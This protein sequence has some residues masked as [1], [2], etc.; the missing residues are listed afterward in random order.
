MIREYLDIKYRNSSSIVETLSAFA[1]FP[2]EFIA[3]PEKWTVSVI[4]AEIPIRAVPI[5]II[6][7]AIEIVVENAS[8]S[9]VLVGSFY[10]PEEFL[11]YFNSVISEFNLG[12]FTLVGELIS[13]KKG[14]KSCSIKFI[15]TS[16]DDLFHFMSFDIRDSTMY[17]DLNDRVQT[18][19]TVS[20][21]YFYKSIGITSSL[22][23][24]QEKVVGGGGF[25]IIPYL[26]DILITAPSKPN[27]VNDMIY[28]VPSAEFRRINLLSSGSIT[29]ISFGAAVY[30]KN[31]I[32]RQ[33]QVKPGEYFNLKL[34]FEK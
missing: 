5:M 4:R 17:L 28:M 18:K 12:T 21:F 1:Q 14:L 6:D 10:T 31:G 9:R 27:E 26:T 19:S 15:D 8:Y 20:R 13:F 11:M 32:T 16:L 23:V 34:L 24:N 22:P 7:T 25:N 33:L 30:Y 2:R 3:D 29:Q